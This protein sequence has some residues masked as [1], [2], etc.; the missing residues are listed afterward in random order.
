MRESLAAACVRMRV[1]KGFH[2]SALEDLIT[3]GSGKHTRF[4]AFAMVSV[5]NS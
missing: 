2:K 4:I 1:S 5:G 3:N